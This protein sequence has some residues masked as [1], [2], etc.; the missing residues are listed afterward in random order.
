MSLLPKTSVRRKTS[1]N[2]AIAVCEAIAAGDFE[3]RITMLDEDGELA[4]LFEA[5][6]RMVDRTDAYIRES[7]AAME[8]V[9]DRKYYRKILTDGMPGSFGRGAGVINAAID[10]MGAVHS[11]SLELIDSV[12]SLITTVNAKVGEITNAA[13][14][15]VTR[16]DT[17][18]SKSL[19]VS[20]AAVRSAADVDS[21]AQATDELV[22]V[23]GEIG[24]QVGDAH[25]AVSIT[26][27]RTRSAGARMESLSQAT[28]RIS[29]VVDLITAIASQTNLLALNA[30]IEAARAG[31]AGKGFAV[32][33][34]EV[35]TLAN[36][37]AKATEDI[38]RQIGD[39]QATT[40]AAS[41]E[42]ERI[43]EVSDRLTRSS[44]GISAAVGRQTEVQS[45]ITDRI[46]HLSREVNRVSE[47]V[48][49]VVQSS[50]QSYASS[51]QVI[52]SAD[53]LQGPA[54]DLSDRIAE[55]SKL[56]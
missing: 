7:S 32:V 26:V 36:Q 54:S 48:V 43:R 47:N 44:E 50:A 27:E 29:S 6:N 56:I 49:N 15:S 4:P 33:A 52:W 19:E 40:K 13:N 23:S 53:D 41:E 46:H 45:A 31:D 22:A 20:E 2:K 37:T 30:T 38:I 16:T 3:A 55:F 34:G 5:I 11:G 25:D 35:K 18:T 21:V 12:Q 39:I 42:I 17:T 24:Q 1:L 28:A 51:I 14:E 10:R 8:S 9:A